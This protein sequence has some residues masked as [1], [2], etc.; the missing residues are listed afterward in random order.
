MNETLW[1]RF[2]KSGS[3]ID[4]LAYVSERTEVMAGADENCGND[5]ETA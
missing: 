5:S 4:Y 2:M 3:V 1:N